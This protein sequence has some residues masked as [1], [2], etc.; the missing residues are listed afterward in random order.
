MATRLVRPRLDA[1]L[2]AVE[3]KNDDFL[4]Q[5]LVNLS[6]AYLLDGWDGAPTSAYLLKLDI[7]IA[8][9]H[10]ALDGTTRVEGV[11]ETEAAFRAAGKTNLTVRVYPGYDHDLNWTAESAGGRG[12][13]PFQDAFATA[14]EL[15][16]G[17]SVRALEDERDGL[18]TAT[19]V[20][21]PARDRSSTRAA[22]AASPRPRRR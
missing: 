8:I 21:T 20:A 7:P 19:P 9:F 16:R 17:R 1:I 18:E 2:K 5:S 10:G 15:L 13:A 4:W 22:R 14:A 3:E 12:P 11:R 6:S